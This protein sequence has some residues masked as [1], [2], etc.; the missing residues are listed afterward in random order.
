MDP[1]GFSGAFI[2]FLCVSASL[3]VQWLVLLKGARG[4]RALRQGV[5]IA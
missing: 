5:E 2:G 1:I 4:Y 3:Q